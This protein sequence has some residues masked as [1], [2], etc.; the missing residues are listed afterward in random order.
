MVE[1]PDKSD[2]NSLYGK[3]C[4][5]GFNSHY[6]TIK[7]QGIGTKTNYIPCNPEEVGPEYDEIVIFNPDQILPRYL[8]HYSRRIYSPT[9]RNVLWVH[10]QPESEDYIKLKRKIEKKATVFTFSTS[11]E[12][13]KW[14]GSSTGTD[15]RIISSKFRKGDGEESAGVRLCQWL[16]Q[17]QKWSSI[18]FMLFCEDGSLVTDLPN[19]DHIHL[20]KNGKDLVK[21]AVKSLK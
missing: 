11:S 20:T 12:L 7:N 1:F 18:P 6:V 16:Q 4:K 10:S 3:P 21:F 9:K 17:E 14:L 8:V 5:E 15:I 13:M 2:P 19:G